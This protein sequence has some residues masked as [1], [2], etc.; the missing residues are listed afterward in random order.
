MAARAGLDPSYVSLL[1]NEK[2]SPGPDTIAALARVFS[3]TPEFL[4]ALAES[5]PSDATC[6]M[7]FLVLMRPN[8]SAE[9]LPQRGAKSTERL[10]I[11]VDC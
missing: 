4:R 1:F 5:N 2:R 7:F 10:N 11:I 3:I 9:D 8:G 6:A